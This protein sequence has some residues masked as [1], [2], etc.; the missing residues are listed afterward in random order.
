LQGRAENPMQKLPLHILH[1]VPRHPSR[2]KELP[3]NGPEHPQ[4]PIIEVHVSIRGGATVDGHHLQA[5][6]NPE[7]SRSFGGSP[8]NH[9][10]QPNGHLLRNPSI[11][12]AV[13]GGSERGKG[14]DSPKGEILVSGWGWF[15]GI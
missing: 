3:H 10:G 7:E 8:D 12:D 14:R 4:H 9:K 1:I 2:N 13:Q 11:R 15:V 6:P 5:V